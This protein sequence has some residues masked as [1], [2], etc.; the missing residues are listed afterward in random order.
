MK[1]ASTEALNQ[2]KGKGVVLFTAPWCK[3]CQALKPNLQKMV[4]EFPNVEFFMVDVDA[5]PDATSFGVRGVPTV[6]FINGGNEVSDRL[7][8]NLPPA[9]YRE[10][11]AK[12]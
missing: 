3:P 5:N 9:R 4:E 12:M 10:V 2:F 11:I 1:P 7:T 8:G 6:M